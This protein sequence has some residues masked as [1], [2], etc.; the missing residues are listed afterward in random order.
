M[1]DAVFLACRLLTI[2]NLPYAQLSSR[3]EYEPDD[4]LRRFLHEYFKLSTRWIDDKKLPKPGL[5][6]RDI[7]ESARIKVSWADNL[8]DNLK[9]ENGEKPV[10]IFH[11]VSFLESQEE[12]CKSIYCSLQGGLLVDVWSI[13]LLSY[14]NSLTKP[15]ALS[16]SSSRYQTIVR[17]SGLRD[18]V[19]SSKTLS[20][21]QTARLR[22]GEAQGHKAKA[23]QILAR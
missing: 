17:G 23:I 7:S 13:V 22:R 2:M 21:T 6:A 20:S 15:S 11:H 16:P 1:Q 9:L 14:T 3:D 19:W 18:S 8:A 4:S 12:V 10:Q 5:T